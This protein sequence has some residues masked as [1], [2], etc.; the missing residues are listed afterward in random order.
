MKLLFDQNI[1]FRIV[2]KLKDEFPDSVQVRRLAL[3]N[4]RDTLIWEYAKKNGFTI[5]TFDTDFYDLSSLYGHPP[6]VIWVRLANPS[7]EEL[8]H[9]LR[10]RS[11][12]IANFIGEPSW[13]E[14]SCLEI[15]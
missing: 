5:V 3:E 7:T 15:G 6:K 2:A 14:V 1:S 13:A 4:R 12:I 8:A 10:I 11:E 9:E